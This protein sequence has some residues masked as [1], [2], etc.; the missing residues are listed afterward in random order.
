MKKYL[1]VALS[2]LALFTTGCAATTAQISLLPTGKVDAEF[3]NVGKGKLHVLPATQGPQV[4]QYGAGFTNLDPAWD[5]KNGIPRFATKADIK[6]VF[7]ERAK[8]TFEQAGYTVTYGEAVPEGTDLVLNQV[9]MTAWQSPFRFNTSTAI[10]TAVLTGGNIA[11]T[12]PIAE[13]VAHVTFAAPTGA[14]KSY[15]ISGRGISYFHLMKQGGL[16]TSFDKAL[17]DYQQ[18]LIKG[19]QVFL[20][21]NSAGGC[22]DSAATEGKCS[23][24]ALPTQK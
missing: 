10:A 17:T 12:T 22:V 24:Q 11:T 6:Q 1:L 16:D 14:R 20:Q 2:L 13:V 5:A 15:L 23:D 3:R 7:G 19:V 4:V 8:T 21:E 18:N 9:I